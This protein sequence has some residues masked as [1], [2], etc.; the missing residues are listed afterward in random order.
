M[1]EISEAARACAGR[2]MLPAWTHDT[3]SEA[4][5]AVIDEAVRRAREE[6]TGD[7][8][9]GAKRIGSP[10][11]DTETPTAP[12]PSPAPA[13]L[14]FEFLGGAPREAVEYVQKDE[15]ERICALHRQQVSEDARG[16]YESLLNVLAGTIRERDEAR[17]EVERLRGEL[18]QTHESL[19][20]MEHQRASDALDGHATMEE[21]NSEILR[22][23]AELAKKQRPALGP[24]PDEV[25]CRAFDAYAS[26]GPDWTIYSGMRAALEAVRGEL[27]Q[28]EVVPSHRSWWVDSKGDL[29]NNILN[30]FDGPFTPV[31]LVRD[32]S[33]EVVR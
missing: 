32:P 3:V 13:R 1:T 29:C 25:C 14:T 22:L 27:C 15:H 8:A 20:E 28:H 16:E 4:L 33:R 2:L 7:G 12:E 18:A 19:R 24:I 31:L 23:R 9:Q 6:R 5:Q 17:A 10:H 30:K 11:T 26:F 21:A